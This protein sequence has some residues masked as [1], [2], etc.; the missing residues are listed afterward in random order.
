MPKLNIVVR[1]Y[2]DLTT[3]GKILMCSICDV[4]ISYDS[5]HSASKIRAHYKTQMNITNKEKKKSTQ[6]FIEESFQNSNVHNQFSLKIAKAFLESG[7][8]LNK[9][10]HPSL[11]SF[12]ENEFQ[13]K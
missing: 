6:T 11:H 12:L 5:K 13:K 4:K 1:K 10:N 9:L 8:P 7:I 3:N 2:P